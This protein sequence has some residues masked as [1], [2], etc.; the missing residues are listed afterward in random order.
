MPILMMALLAFLIFG[1]IG[2][3]LTVAVVLE[4]SKRSHL[5]KDNMT[6]SAR[7]G[8]GAFLNSPFR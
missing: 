3:L 5:A 2:I 7:S 4:H 6:H 1:L 8:V